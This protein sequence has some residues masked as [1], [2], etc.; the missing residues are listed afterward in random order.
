MY[1]R[2]L[3]TVGG[4]FIDSNVDKDRTTDRLW[5]NASTYH[6]PCTKFEW[7]GDDA[8]AEDYI[9]GFS[10]ENGSIIWSTDQ[11]FYGKSMSAN[12]CS[13]ALYTKSS[14]YNSSIAMKGGV[15]VNS[16]FA[17]GYARNENNYEVLEASA[18]NNSI[19]IY[20]AYAKDNSISMTTEI[21]S[22][23][24]TTV[25]AIDNSM[26]LMHSITKNE[27]TLFTNS[28][29]AWR[30]DTHSGYALSVDNSYIVPTDTIDLL[31]VKN[32]TLLAAVANKPEENV[33][34]TH[35]IASNSY[36]LQYATSQLYNYVDSLC[37]SLTDCGKDTTSQYNVIS[38]VALGANKLESSNI[39]NSLLLATHNTV[40]PTQDI[41]T[42]DTINLASPLSTTAEANCRVLMPA[43]AI[44]K[45][46]TVSIANNMKVDSLTGTDESLFIS[47]EVLQLTGS[48]KNNVI[49]AS[50]NNIVYDSS[51]SIGLLD[52]GISASSAYGCIDCSVS[53]QSAVVMLN[54]TAISEDHI[55]AKS[56]AIENAATSADESIAM[57]SSKIAKLNSNYANK[58]PYALAM[59]DG[60]PTYAAS[61]TSTADN[62]LSFWSDALRKRDLPVTQFK[63]ISTISSLTE[64]EDDVMYIITG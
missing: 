37:I 12:L 30:C 21:S 55:V 54:S 27:T 22:K 59:F 13:I 5:S 9:V 18:I 11:A 15:A 28:S 64:L 53:Q 50:K 6:Y 35:T 40:K 16:S 63:K 25:S 48:C 33:S 36:L 43:F 17:M 42:I 1:G 26:L 4:L 39:V 47:D 49:L 58:V 51:C 52:T 32:K 34:K 23:D 60:K 41:Y 10:P 56:L 46:D 8:P 19:A 24:Y 20:A 31:D 57:F 38:S 2:F 45:Q 3:D 62:R 7:T 44:T 29:F 14:A 61:R